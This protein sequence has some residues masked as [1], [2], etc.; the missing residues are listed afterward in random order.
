M[1]T[2]RAA[3]CMRCDSGPAELERARLRP[4]ISFAPIQLD[5]SLHARSLMAVRS[6]AG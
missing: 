6:C 1:N 3:E 2:A 5:E 4:L